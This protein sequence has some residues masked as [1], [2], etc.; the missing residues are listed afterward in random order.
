MKRT[1]KREFDCVCYYAKLFYDFN[2]FK[3]A[4]RVAKAQSNQE[5]T[6]IQMFWQRVAARIQAYHEFKTNQDR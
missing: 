3:W 1:H 4:L 5:S 2:G 6:N